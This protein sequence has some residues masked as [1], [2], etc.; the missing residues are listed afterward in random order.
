MK[1]HIKK[2]T[3]FTLIELIVSM[4]IVS[5]LT[6]GMIA[7]N[8]AAMQRKKYEIFQNNVETVLTYFRYARSDA[9]TNRII[10]AGVPEGGFGVHLEYDNMQMVLT[11]FVDDD[12][13]EGDSVYTDGSDTQ[14]DQVTIPAPWTFGFENSSPD[15]TLDSTFTTIFI[16]PNANMVMNDGTAINDLRSVDLVFTF[17]PK[18]K[19]IC[20]NR[21]SRFF[22]VVTEDQC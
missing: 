8:D 20:L 9:I 11:H 5:L 19:R 17:G 16:P 3:G 1:K 15:T 22:E 18:E 14:L 4:A 7:M 6:F 21:V 13:S 12:P 10:G 2:T